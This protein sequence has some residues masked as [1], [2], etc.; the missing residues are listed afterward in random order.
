[1]LERMR[2]KV[3]NVRRKS[4][5]RR[6]RPS[7]GGP[8]QAAAFSLLAAGAERDDRITEETLSQM[9]R[10]E[11]DGDDLAEPPLQAIAS[12]P[13][14]QDGD[15][16]NILDKSS[17]E[18]SPQRAPPHAAARSTN[19]S[20]TP[21]FDGVREMFRQPRAEPKTPSFTGIRKMFH[22]RSEMP[23]KTPSL[24]GVREMF[25]RPMPPDV[26]PTPHM[27][28]GDMF[29]EGEG[30]KGSGMKIDPIDE[31][32]DTN[33]G[34]RRTP[35]LAHGARA[36]KSEQR[37]PASP[38]PVPTKTST[39][40]RKVATSTEKRSLRKKGVPAVVDQQATGEEEIKNEAE[41][42]EA[43][44]PAADRRSTKRSPKD[45]TT[46]TPGEAGP[47]GEG[48]GR[49]AS[50]STRRVA[51][52]TS[53]N[54]SKGIVE[55]K[56]TRTRRA[57]HTYSGDEEATDSE[58]K[59][60]GSGRSKRADKNQPVNESNEEAA[61]EAARVGSDSTSFVCRPIMVVIVRLLGTPSQA[62]IEATLQNPLTMKELHRPRFVEGVLLK[63][64]RSRTIV[65]KLTTRQQLQR[66]LDASGPKC[67][68]PWNQRQSISE[69]D[70]A[71]RTMLWK[72]LTK[73]CYKLTITPP[74]PKTLPQSQREVKSQRRARPRRHLRPRTV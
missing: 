3:A 74:N 66:L 47:A 16:L 8:Q 64:G 20:L 63:P 41:D 15:D 67:H 56:T 7:I 11:L 68:L 45:A 43:Q 25:D 17:D 22:E 14:V 34:K 33:A 38:V 61:Q 18:E 9:K 1:M 13:D 26:P 29:D 69:R 55:H 10:T 46:P 44:P 62:L 40:T 4:E 73:K 49:G 27:D 53:Q 21:R 19:V 39:R 57:A 51:A 58:R 72:W 30:D 71:R 24:R 48:S 32:Q 54:T 50:R 42:A 59:T 5:A 65:T 12:D 35:S 23:P 60:K 31:P 2:Q 36:P 6:T 28:L 37:D 52:S 70:E